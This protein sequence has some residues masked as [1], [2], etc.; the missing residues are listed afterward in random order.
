[1]FSLKDGAPRKLNYFT[2]Y[3]EEV[4]VQLK[5]KKI[6]NQA[7][8]WEYHHL[9]F[10][11]IHYPAGKSME[12]IWKKLT[13]PQKTILTLGHLI[14]QTN[15]GGVWQFLFNKPE[16][17][18]VALE[19]LHEINPFSIF[20][21]AYEPV[22]QE[23]INLLENGTYEDIMTT[24]NDESQEFEKRWEAFK[25]GQEH[26]PSREKFES[27]FFNKKDMDRLY[28]KAVAYI[29]Q[30]LGKLVLVETTEAT[31]PVIK[32]KDAIPHFTQYITQ[33]MGE[34]PTEV[35]V[36]YTGRVTLNLQA[37]QLFL[38]KFKMPSGYESIGITGNFTYHLPEVTLDDINKM[39]K[40]YHKQELVNIYHGCHLV[41]ETLQK[42]PKA[43]QVNEEKWQ[44]LLKRLQ[45]P[46][47][48]QVPVNVTLKAYFKLDK[49][50]WYIYTGDLLY[51]DNP[52][53]FPKDLSQ[54]AVLGVREKTKDENPLRG[55]LN[56]IFHTKD[57][58]S[59]EPGFG[60]GNLQE[61]VVGKYKL[62]DVVGNQYKII[63]DN[64]WGF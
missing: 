34:A 60:R 44:K 24:W 62:Y 30:N 2:T 17:S 27:Y 36:Y 56:L 18:L 57:S 26:I 25:S 13:K 8:F 10:E 29:E 11:D 35:S 55:E 33:A 16:F 63:K 23:F 50:E 40:K 58:R 42:N 20:M 9:V 47:H 12:E 7:L 43:N 28:Q 31:H 54:V 59:K 41:Q 21:S 61:A 22:F 1:M 15:N 53:N 49:N 19:A 45:D 32:K 39:Y 38:M 64:P 6:D 4:L 51:N 46:S 48:S 14:N 5:T 3:K 37:T 52:G